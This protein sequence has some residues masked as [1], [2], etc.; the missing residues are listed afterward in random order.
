MHGLS[1]QKLEAMA[2]QHCPMLEWGGIMLE[3]H[4]Q[5]S[6]VQCRN[7]VFLCWRQWQFSIVQCWNGA[8][9]CWRQW[10]FS[11][12][13]CW[14]GAVLCWR[15]WQFSIVQCRNGA[16]L[17]WLVLCAECKLCVLLQY[18]MVGDLFTDNEAH[19]MPR[20]RAASR[21]GKNAAKSKR[22]VGSEVC[23]LS[24]H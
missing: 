21:T 5:F 3:E 16:V 4:W 10:Q 24:L 22:S 2:I 23:I 9:L 6:I 17:C 19:L 1:E 7:M 15:Q 20:K 13:Q 14:N 12:V 8:V 11:I 18:E